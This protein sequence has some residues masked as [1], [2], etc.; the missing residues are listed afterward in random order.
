MNHSQWAKLH[1][2]TIPVLNRILTIDTRIQIQEYGQI[3][4]CEMEKRSL[5]DPRANQI[6]P[7][8]AIPFKTGIV[9]ACN[10]LLML[11]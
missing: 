2:G 3:V 9:P 4:W 8:A 10:C 11:S 1:A 6:L 7:L 5:H